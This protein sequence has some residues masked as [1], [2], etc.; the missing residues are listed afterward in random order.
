MY[1]IGLLKLVLAI[2]RHTEE[3]EGRG[4]GGMRLD[5]GAQRQLGCMEIAALQ[6]GE[7]LADGV[8]GGWEKNRAKQNQS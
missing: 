7:G 6:G 1:R 2:E 3:R 4:I 8:G 5:L